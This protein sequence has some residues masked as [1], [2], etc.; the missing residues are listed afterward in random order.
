MPAFS[1]KALDPRGKL[2]KGVIEGDSERQ[3]RGQ[4]RAKQLKPVAVQQSSGRQT[5]E[6]RWTPLRHL[7]DEQ[8]TATNIKSTST[9]KNVIDALERMIQ[10]LK[11]YE[12][13]VEASAQVVKTA[14]ETLGTLLDIMA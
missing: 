8:G 14:D 1:Y 4:L 12:R 2:I 3:A 9:R 10:H 13:S 5:T 6:K 7:S 11:L